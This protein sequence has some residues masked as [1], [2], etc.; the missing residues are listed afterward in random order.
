MDG[1]GDSASRGLPCRLATGQTP[2]Y[3]VNHLRRN[4]F[5]ERRVFHERAVV[6][7]ADQLPSSLLGDLFEQKR[8]AARRARL[9][10]GPLP[11]REL[12]VGIIR[13]PVERLPSSR[14]ALDDVAAVGRA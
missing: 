4:R 5:L 14:L 3:D 7:A 8:C 10:D 1:D 11:Q 9:G 13:A 12:A 2:A 6:L